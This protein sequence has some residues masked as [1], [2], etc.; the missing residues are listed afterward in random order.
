MPQKIFISYRRE[1]AGANALGISQYLEH[2]FGRKNVFIDIDMRAGTNFPAVLEQRLAEC[3]VMLV[4]IGPEWLN[5]RDEQGH[6]RLDIPDDWVRLEIARALKRNITVIPVRVNGATLPLRETLPE[7]IRGLLDHQAVS[8]TLAGFRNEMSGLVRDIRSIPSPKPSWLR[9]GAIAAGLLIL[10]LGLGLF[11]TNAIERI[12]L[13]L[14]S[15]T[16]KTE[17]QNLIWS[18]LPGEWVMYAFDTKPVAYYFKPS[19]IKVFGDQVAY[20]AR[21]PVNTDA[22]PAPQEQI[23]D[24]G[25]YEENCNRTGLQKIHE[26]NRRNNHF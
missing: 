2:E 15:H 18:S 14:Y 20:T 26:P 17:T 13:L 12:R 25:A 7:D 10:L 6:R 23:S 21:W 16:S 8:V 24:R 11:Q 1:D 22:P 5:A 19:S 4:L 9:Y 3:K